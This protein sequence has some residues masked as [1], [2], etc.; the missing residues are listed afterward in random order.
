MFITGFYFPSP[1]ITRMI[2]HSFFHSPEWF[3]V[4]QQGFGVHK[5]IVSS[6]EV[7]VAFAIFRVGPFRLAYANFPIGLVT[8]EELNTTIKSDTI[9]L[10]RERGIHILNFTTRYEITSC[11]KIE[12][13]SLPETVI[14]N[15]VN[16]EESR[17]PSDMRYKLRRSKREGLRIRKA[18]T[19]DYKSLHKIYI[20]TVD[21][22]QGQVRYSLKYFQAL[23]TLA[24]DNENLDCR[25]AL[26][27]DSDNPCGFIVV[28]HDGEIAYYLHGGYDLRYARLRSGYGLMS[29]AIAYARDKGC[30]TFNLMASPV[31]QP[32]LVKFKEKWGG[33]THQITSRREALNV[34]GKLLMG[35]LHWRNR[36]T[37]LLKSNLK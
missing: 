21:R 22:H 30:K 11:S 5:I 36:C 14:E 35:V 27:A 29:L 8:I 25:V 33:V 3:T 15:L 28:A 9:Q 24:E 7:P 32:D 31:D 4:L 10:L 13:I 12:N 19:G 17:L 1:K 34:P 2:N 23:T 16:W 18:H 37:N 20:D 6:E 26:A